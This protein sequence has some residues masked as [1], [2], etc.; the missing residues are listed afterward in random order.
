MKNQKGE[1]LSI[2]N[3]QVGVFSRWLAFMVTFTGILC[4][5]VLWFI[6]FSQETSQGPLT[7]YFEM[8]SPWVALTAGIALF[9]RL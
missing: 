6:L 8:L 2:N 5:F 3:Q 1:N 4:A 7:N 9:L